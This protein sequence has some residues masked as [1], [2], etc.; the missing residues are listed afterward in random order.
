TTTAARSKHP[1]PPPSRAHPS[2]VDVTDL[3]C[4]Q[5]TSGVVSRPETAHSK[6]ILTRCH[7]PDTSSP[8]R[9][10]RLAPQNPRMS[11]CP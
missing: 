5:Q 8:P 3:D 4:H 6:P 9:L 10:P 11:T 2:V 7:P 1:S